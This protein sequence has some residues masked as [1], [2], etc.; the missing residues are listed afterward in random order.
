MEN[1]QRASVKSCVKIYLCT[2]P[3]DSV[4]ERRAL[5]EDVFPRVREHCRRTH[6]LE[7]RVIDPYE[8]LTPQEVLDPRAQQVTLQLL[9]ECRKNSAGPFLVALVGGQ[10]GRACLPTEV[11]VS[12]FQ[13]VLRT[14]QRMGICTQVLERWYQRD[15]NII[16]PSFCLL[17]HQHHDEV[18]PAGNQRKPHTSLSIDSVLQDSSNERL[19]QLCDHFLPSLV[20]SHKLLVYTSTST[21]ELPQGYTAEMRRWYI[22]GLCQQ[23]H[24]D[25]LSLID[26]TVTG[27]PA[28][29]DDALSQELVQQTDLCQIYSSLY[30]IECA[31]VEHVKAYL[32]EKDTKYPLI[33][34]GGPCTGK[35]VLLAHCAQQVRTWFDGQDPVVVIYFIN[36]RNS[37]VEKLLESLCYQLAK[38]YNLPHHHCPLHISHLKEDFIR[39]LATVS[40]SP[41]PLVL[42]LDGLDQMPGADRAQSVWWLPVSLPVN[43]KLLISTAPKKSGTLKALRALYPKSSL[44][45]EVGPKTSRDCSRMLVD[46][47]VSCGRRITSG[48]QMYVN[49]ALRECSLPLYVQLLHRQLCTWRSESDVTENSLTKG[50]HNNIRQF[51]AQL[52]QKH[53]K[54]LVSKA[55]CY[56]TLAKSGITEAE[57]TDILSCDDDVL[58]QYLPLRKAVPYRFRVPEAIVEKMLQDLRGFLTTQ[59]VCGFQVLFWPSRHFPLVIRKLYLCSAEVVRDIHSALADYFSGQWSYGRTKPV[60]NSWDRV[61]QPEPT[62]T[63]PTKI[64]VDRQI[65]GQ[66]WVFDSSSSEQVGFNVRKILELPFHL[67]ASGRLE[68]LSRDVIM[69]PGFHQSMLNAGRLEELVCELEESSMFISSQELELLA[70]IVRDA[71]CLLRDSPTYLTTVM[72]AKL[73]P[74]LGVLPGLEGYAK[75]I[76]QE[77]VRSHGVNVV[78]SPVAEVPSAHWA[79]PELTA[80]PVREVLDTQGNTA[81]MLLFDGSVWTWNENVTG[82]CKPL[83]LSDFKISSVKSWGH[84]LMLSTCCN[85]TFLYNLK[86]LSCVCEINV[87]KFVPSSPTEPNVALPIQGFVLFGS[88]MILWYKDANYLWMFDV[89]T[90]VRIAQL[91][92]HHTVTSVSTS[93]NGQFIFCGQDKG[94]VSIFNIR[95]KCHLATRRH[96]GVSIMSILHCEDDDLMVCVN[97]FGHVFVW[98][99]ETIT[100]PQLRQKCCN[101]EDQEEVLNTEHSLENNTLLVC[102]RSQIAL[103]DTREWTLDDQF[104]APQGRTFIQAVLAKDGLLIIACLENCPF[105]L[106]WKRTTGQCIL[107]LDIGHTQ[108][109]KILK[110]G[111]TLSVVTTNGVVTNWDLDLIWG[112]SMVAKAR[113]R[114]ENLV[115][116]STGQRFYTSDGTEL[117]WKWDALS[118]RAEGCFL[119]DGWVETFAVS[120][121]CERLVSASSEDIYVWQTTTGE[122]LHRIRSAGVCDLLITPNCN[123]AVSLCKSNLSPVWKLGTGHVVCNVHLY[124]RNA[125]ISPESTFILGLYNCD[126]LAVSL[127]SGCISKR[128]SC[129]GQSEVIAFQPLLDHTDYV[130][131]ITISGSLYTWNV[132]EETVC[133]HVRLPSALLIKPELF[134]VS[135]DGCYAVLSTAGA[136]IN[137]LDTLN[138]KLC[139]LQAEGHVLMVCLDITGCYVIFICDVDN[140]GGCTCSLHSRPILNAVRVSDGKNVGRFYL[141]KSPSALSLAEDL[142]AYVGFEDGSVGVY[143]ITDATESSVMVGR[144]LR[145]MGRG[146]SCLCEEPQ[147][148]SPLAK[149]SIT[150]MNSAT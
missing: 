55:M 38:S 123:F 88:K 81:V 44:F 107:S 140:P 101:A 48:Q 37:T 94:T 115:V 134:Q 51:M 20:T 89:T 23:L 114:V 1:F 128:F 49:Q 58:S 127:W 56:L 117:V 18:T 124:L 97:R 3:E 33:L 25:L 74:F 61:M 13:E 83:H 10:Y 28:H 22:E 59:N 24:A 144:C 75:Q 17:G 109:L 73:F 138:G 146:M 132:T 112:A 52:E 91:Q 43:V 108:A 145:S 131:L 76:Y 79:L 60:L 69:S 133:K 78:R 65:P 95:N 85:K 36:D 104:N 93:I 16:P 100:D 119:H 26:S 35:T 50:I 40:S 71:S 2:N 54:K 42:I 92:C 125:V 141:C 4:E 41:H 19:S 105:L 66:P 122:N 64:Y 136:T 142:C 34:I 90:G 129:S 7:F 46:L 53:G 32:Q 118:S 120:T 139:S 5:R 96:S 99:I 113:A 15:E 149:P 67:K 14:G 31:E 106:V 63:S 137:I 80:T 11:E 82:G 45:V 143:A 62:S 121:D 72:Q 84:F 12:E 68:E 98:D 30:R 27:K 39:L 6:G 57:L 130:V 111:S 47:M 150:W 9:E 103:W 147:R 135:M 148:W 87:H 21:Y 70:S 126:L 77:G 86:T 8:G 29:L 110:I 116:E 102:K